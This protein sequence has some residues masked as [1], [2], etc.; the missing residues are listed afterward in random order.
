MIWIPISHIVYKSKFSFWYDKI[1]FND[2]TNKLPIIINLFLDTINKSLLGI[3]STSIKLS[4]TK[5]SQTSDCFCFC[6][7][8]STSFLKPFSTP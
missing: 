5:D 8:I 6:I 4:N 2:A 3:P 1:L 7:F